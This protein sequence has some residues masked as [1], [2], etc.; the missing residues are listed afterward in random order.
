[1]DFSGWRPDIQRSINENLIDREK[2]R[3]PK[4]RGGKKYLERIDRWVFSLIDWISHREKSFPGTI[5]FALEEEVHSSDKTP[6]ATEDVKIM[7]R[8]HMEI[9]SV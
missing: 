8:A 1:M 3:D 7:F 4:Y 6:T 5:I 2:E 9:G